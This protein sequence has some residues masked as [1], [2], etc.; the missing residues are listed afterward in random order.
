MGIILCSKKLLTYRRSDES[1]L[2][3]DSST[4]VSSTV[5]LE[6]TGV[7]TI[8]IVGAGGGGAGTQCNKAI[9]DAGGLAYANWSG[10]GSG[11][12]FVGTIQLQQ[13]NYSYRIGNK[14][15]GKTTPLVYSNVY[16][17]DGE[18][19]F[20]KFT[21]DNNRVIVEVGG[22]YG[23][24]ATKSSGYS[25]AGSGGN[26]GTLTRPELYYKEEVNSG[27]GIK[28]KTNVL[29][30]GQSAS[31]QAKGGPSVYDDTA[32]GYGAGGKAGSSGV[33]GYIRLEYI[34][35]TYKA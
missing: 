31:S 25:S 14:G 26:G 6:K 8:V 34:G 9:T 3:L 19:S 15:S 13:G 1:K 29:A 28:G 22:G 2:Y 21:D 27:D 18:S 30:G 4:P 12:C 7:Y 17:D 11:A 24:Y 16:G 5:Y 33:N 20:L 10:G 23:G 32:S 35:R